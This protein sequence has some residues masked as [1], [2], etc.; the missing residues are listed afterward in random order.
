MKSC[1]Y[2]LEIIIVRNLLF[3]IR[4]KNKNFKMLY[5]LLQYPD[6]YH[7]LLQSARPNKCRLSQTEH[8]IQSEIVLVLN[9]LWENGKVENSKWLLKDNYIKI[10][11]RT[12]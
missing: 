8:H 7:T 9:N 11:L 12:T 3:L 2:Y 10:V 5:F 1:L 4:L 6:R